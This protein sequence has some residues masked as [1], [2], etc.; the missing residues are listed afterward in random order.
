MENKSPFFISII[1]LLLASIGYSNWIVLSVGN[2]QGENIAKK[3]GGKPVAYTNENNIKKEYTS[4]E[5]ALNHTNSGTIYLISGTNPTIHSD[6][7]IKKGVTLALPYEDD[8]NNTHKIVLEKGDNGSSFSDN[9]ESKRNNLLTIDKAT[10]N[11]QGTLSIGGVT[12]GEGVQGGTTGAYSEILMKSANMVVTGE[13]KCYGFIKKDDYQNNESTIKFTQELNKNISSALLETPAVFYDYSSATNLLK[14]KMNGVFPFNQFDVPQIRPTMIFSYGSTLSGRVHTYG[15]TAGDIVTS[16]NLIS[17][18]NAFICMGENSLVTW[19]YTDIDSKKT[20]NSFKNHTTDISLSGSGSMGSLSVK[21][22]SFATV[23][24]KDHYLPVPC[25]YNVN[26]EP[27]SYFSM[28]SALK[29]IKFMPGSSLNCEK[30][31]VLDIDTSALFYQSNKASDGTSFNYVSTKAAKLVN[32]GVININNGFEGVVD[33]D[34]IDGT[35]KINIGAEYKSVSDCKEGTSKS[36]YSWGG[37]KALVSL[38]NIVPTDYS[39]LAKN[40]SYKSMD[41]YWVLNESKEI[42][43]ISIT[44]DSYAS[45]SN[46]EGNFQITLSI[47]PI[48]HDCEILDYSWNCSPAGADLTLSDDKKSAKLKTPANSSDS[49]KIYTVSCVVKYRTSDGNEK[50]LT[51]KKDFTASKKSGG[52]FTRGTKILTSNGL[53]KEIENLKVGDKI[54]SFSHETGQIEDQIITYIPYHSLNNYQVLELHFENKK[55]IKVLFAHGFMNALTK[56]Y[57][58]ISLNNVENKIGQSYLFL[59]NGELSESK[60]I[61]YNSYEEI[62]ECFSLSTAYNLN[63]FVE[64]ALCISDDISGL[65]NYFDLDNNYKYDE[66]KKEKDI[67]KYGLLNYED[68]SY[69]MSKEI[70]EYFNVKYLGVSIGKG[71]ITMKEMEDYI[72]RFA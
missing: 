33:T 16:A 47:D 7:T 62:T 52:C 3:I 70:Y 2:Y 15:D 9:D 72:S 46:K 25:G 4:V 1:L 56:K 18:S 40:T 29:G 48:D 23:D 69:F 20:N 39:S 68:V 65:Y 11:V 63:H 49:D 22:M 51:C 60:L 59:E 14:I 6:C 61:S 26:L 5:A 24:S 19:K 17:T 27:N 71:L 41:N 28:P 55:K 34:S 54:K 8:G 58:E 36:T 66:V 30:G 31:S 21:V 12:G 10:L 44:S 64:G 53:Y 57:E 45:P 38:E 67:E 43:S 35:A 42:R 50:E 32:N 37:A 13:L